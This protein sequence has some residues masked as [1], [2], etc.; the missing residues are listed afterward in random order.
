MDTSD[1]PLDP[2]QRLQKELQRVR[3]EKEVLASQHRTLLSRLTTMRD[4]L[5]NKLKKDAEELDR[6]EQLVQRLQAQNDDLE[7]TVDALKTELLTAHADAERVARELD[8]LRGRALEESTLEA[9]RRESELREAQA[10][11]ERA[12]I[13]R[14]D[15]EVMAMRERMT[16][17]EARAAL[18]ATRRELAVEREAAKRAL[19]ERDV[20][21]GNARNLQSVLEDFQAA[22]DHEIKQSVRE[23]ER[24]LLS[25]TQS[26]AEF[27]HRALQAELAIEESSTN[28]TRMKELER[29]VKEKS[30]L[31]DK[32]RHEAVII[33]EHLMEAL[34]RLRRNSSDMNVDRR[35]VTNI[36][37][38]FLTTPRADAKRFE[39]L[40][41]LASI[42]SWTDEERERAGLQRG[43]GG[44]PRA[45]NTPKTRPVELD[46]TDETESFSR[47]WVEFLLT[48]AAAG[49][50]QSETSSG[51]RS[52]PS[53]PS[54]PTRSARSVSGGLSPLTSLGRTAAMA[55][56]PD[57]SVPP[58][59]SRKGK[60]K[61]VS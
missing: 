33:N 59:S 44:A 35:L 43:S 4:T 26:L 49:S 29:E 12:H 58:M 47:L 57:L 50:P 36:L 3:E 30:L 32:L 55:S 37:L 34:R 13:E 46:K 54:S 60:E 31:T 7:A 16:A 52:S 10:G 27:K 1:T 25:A 61:A 21:R 39:M 14:D 8:A 48:E 11:L 5:G 15:W 38:Q 18:E 19:A 41:L 51:Q 53:L 6:R 56:S 20:E 24:Q 42:L 40:M 17:D 22:K 9:S 28:T 23:Y 45:I 2:Y